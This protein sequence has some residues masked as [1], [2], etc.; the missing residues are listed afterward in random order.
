[1]RC[2]RLPSPPDDPPLLDDLGRL[3]DLAMEEG[4]AVDCSF[5]LDT[6]H[7]RSSCA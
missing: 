4:T 3:L 7:T 6:K 1:M 5:A 2:F